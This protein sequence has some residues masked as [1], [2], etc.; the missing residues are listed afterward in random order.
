[1]GRTLI[2]AA[3]AALTTVFATV[4]ANAEGR[5][6]LV[7]ANSEYEHVPTLTN[8]V[9]D[10]ADIAAA[11]ERLGFD[12]E[13]VSDQSFSDM[14]TD[15][16]HLR[17]RVAG[18][19]I[20]IVYYA[21]HGIEVDNQNFLIPVDA[22]LKTDG[23]VEFEAIPLDLVMR[24]VESAKQL[25]LVIVDACRNNPFVSSMRRADSSRSIGRGLAR[26][27]PSGNTLVAFAAKE[28]TTAADG[29]DR[30]SPYAAALL[31][32]I[33][34]PGLEIGLLFRRVRDSVLEATGNAQEP[35]LYGSLSSAGIYLKEGPPEPEPRSNAQVVVAPPSPGSFDATGIEITFWNSV[36]DS[37]DPS[38]LR[39]YLGR[40][41]EGAF[42]DIANVMIERLE[43]NTERRE[44]SLTPPDVTDQEVTRPA[45]GA[46]RS[47]G[48][49][50]TL[51][52][53]V[54]EFEVAGERRP[55]IGTQVARIEPQMA[56]VLG[57]PG[58]AG[59]AVISVNRAGP[60]DLA[61]VRPGDII[62]EFNGQKITDM[63]DLPRLS[64][65]VP[66]GTEVTVKLRRY[67]E[68]LGQLM[69]VL[70]EAADRGDQDAAW[71]LFHFYAKGY[72]GLDDE[73]A[74]RRWARAAAEAGDAEAQY[75]MSLAYQE[76]DGVTADNGEA[77][78]WA[79]LAAEQEHATA[80]AYVGYAYENGYGVAQDLYEAVR[81]YR[82][83]AEAGQA[84]AQYSLGRAYTSGRGGV[85][86]DY[87]EAMNW[88]RKSAEQGNANAQYEISIAYQNGNGVARDDSEALIWARKAAAQEHATALAYVGHAYEQ[89]LGVTK[90]QSEALNW[91][92]K[93]A[94]L[95]QAFAQLALGRYYEFGLDGITADIDEAVR[96]YR[97]AADQ[98]NAEAQAKVGDA[99]MWGHGAPEDEPESLRWY[100]LAVD[101]GN[102]AGMRGLGFAYMYGYGVEK[103]EAEAVRWYLKAAEGG[104]LEGQRRLGYA[105]ANGDGIAEDDAEAV[106]WW[107][108][109]ADRGDAVSQRAMGFAYSNGEGVT[110]DDVEALRWWKLA[111]DQ[112][113]TIAEAQ[114]GWAYRTGTGVAID[115]YEAAKWL[116]IAA[117]KGNLPAMY[118]LGAAYDDG[119]G[120]TKDRQES[121][122]LIY[123]AIRK[124]ND[125]ALN[126]MKTNDGAWSVEFRQAL[127]RLLRN[128]GYYSGS[129]DGQFGPATTRALDKLYNSA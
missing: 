27:E 120:V 105:Y 98:G 39:L 86:Q 12:V 56:R 112:G 62:L 111:A 119:D 90:D 128:N 1:M 110:K 97:Q 81:W 96:W 104:D 7:I 102:A 49:D 60:A 66:T 117:D 87:Y 9:N 72:G 109:A 40:Y 37:G 36:K 80:R 35:F 50:I 103:D 94:D 53:T 73:S 28:G 30:N 121:A 126:Q 58:G 15:L 25:R 127:Q 122:R 19:D 29:D 8:P 5:V 21:G 91:Y 47:I 31:E 77:L 41:P 116:R 55:A 79:R 42:A 34:E 59:T 83:A 4:S 88:F 89:G 82:Q 13:T 129:I 44:A 101:Q 61:G 74:K 113:E 23:D 64:G 51:R 18:S 6:A 99:Y 115:H 16:Q 78:R 43:G 125:F 123:E 11:L 26:V 118:N 54:G 22:A 38:M 46:A 84:Y 75:A 100:H 85:P 93:A 57:L 68:S 95:G 17:S 2:I 10:A 20:A 45:S 69:H 33:E 67:G 14:R 92:R 32:H 106:R 108:T 124:G 52:I 3:I 70:E 71:T 76:G 65:E 48:R 107:R 63:P 24:A 114:V